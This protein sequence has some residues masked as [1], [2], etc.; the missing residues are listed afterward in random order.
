MTE[1]AHSAIVWVADA[2]LRAVLDS[3]PTRVALLDRDRRYIYINREYAAFA[4]KTEQRNP[5]PHDPR[6]AGGG[7]VRHV[8]PAR[9]TGAGRRGR[10]VGR[11]AGIPSGPALSA[12]ALST[13][14]RRRRRGG[15]VFHL[16]SRPDGPETKRAGA[17]RTTRRAY[18]KRGAE[19]RDHR[20]G[21][22]LR[23][24]DR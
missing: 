9:G 4:G 5:R 23:H 1:P 12:T 21:A 11:L 14:V 8:L 15:R 19:Y 13:A 3:I 18:G 17:G 2:Q 10:A 20:L 7:G 16:Q 6:G 24:R 22:G